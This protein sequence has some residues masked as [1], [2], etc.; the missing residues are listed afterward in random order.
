MVVGLLGFFL[1]QNKGCDI[2]IDPS[3]PETDNSISQVYS[4]MQK[5][6]RENYAEAV[7]K[8]QA[9]ELADETEFNTFLK[10]SNASDLDKAFE[11]LDTAIAKEFSEE[12]SPEAA[13]KFYST[14]VEALR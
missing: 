9:G 7:A 8:L 11:P 10:N 12:W 14:V 3:P 5:L 1:Y 13:I 6:H 4:T 2:D